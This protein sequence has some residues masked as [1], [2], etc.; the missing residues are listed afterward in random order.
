MGEQVS[1]AGARINVNLPG[2]NNK[3]TIL[4]SQ[5]KEMKDDMD[6]EPGFERTNNLDGNKVKSIPVVNLRNTD[7]NKTESISGTIPVEPEAVSG[8]DSGDSNR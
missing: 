5:G 4:T 6:A 1:P 8:A 3:I 7:G 2:D